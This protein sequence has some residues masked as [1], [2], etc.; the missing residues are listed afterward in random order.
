MSHTNENQA[1]ALLRELD[2]GPVTALQALER[3][4]IS[5]TAARVFELRQRG[6]DITSQ[7]VEV[8]NRHGEL[9]RV[10]QYTLA[11]RHRQLLPVREHGRG[12]VTA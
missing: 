12:R 11:A 3:L 6:F 4:G 1:D 9:C 2:R 5:R 8:R 10:A 7:M